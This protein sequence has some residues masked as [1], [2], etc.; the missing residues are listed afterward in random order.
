[1]G[2]RDRMMGFMPDLSGMQSQLNDKFEELIAELKTMQ[3]ILADI[4]VEL[5]TQRGGTLQ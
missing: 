2:I 3:G 1:M 5:R 4:L